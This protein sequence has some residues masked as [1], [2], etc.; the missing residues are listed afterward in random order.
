MCVRSD[1]EVMLGPPFPKAPSDGYLGDVI[2]GSA[3][4]GVLS[5]SNTT[6]KFKE[7]LIIDPSSAAASAGAGAGTSIGTIFTFEAKCSGSF[8]PTVDGVAVSPKTS[9]ADG[10]KVYRLDAEPRGGGAQ[11]IETYE[12]SFGTMP[13]LCCAV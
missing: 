9:R 7:Q 8:S 4:L 11:S 12:A 2:G 5:G 13:F 6:V 3:V 1:V 10:Y